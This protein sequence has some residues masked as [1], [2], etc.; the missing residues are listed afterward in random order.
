MIRPAIA[1]LLAGVLAG[2]GVGG[3]G[4]GGKATTTTT[5]APTSTTIPR[6]IYK[7]PPTLL[8]Q[9]VNDVNNAAS[10]SLTLNDFP[11]GWRKAEPTASRTPRPAVEDEVLAN[12]LFGEN[13]SAL[14]AYVVSDMYVPPENNLQMRSFVRVTNAKTNAVNDFKNFTS[15]RV[16]SCQ[17]GMYD[18]EQ[19]P[20]EGVDEVIGTKF[21]EA[22]PLPM[23]V[24]KLSLSD[25]TTDSLGFRMIITPT[26]GV[27]I[28]Q[29]I[30]AYGAGRY[31]TVMMV[32]AIVVPDI[33]QETDIFKRLKTRAL[34]AARLG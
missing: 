25:S 33:N 21:A 10:V 14:S 15:A 28:H 29:D 20:P 11:Q 30:F 16:Q 32:Q 19:N 24:D 23:P 22:V 8:T 2:C 7:F 13:P 9:N 27:A 12:C 26:D 5:A 6:A 17:D 34:A 1:L 18:Y 4:G 3:I 31:E